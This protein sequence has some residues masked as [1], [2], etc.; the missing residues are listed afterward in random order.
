M[1]DIL[2]SK[3]KYYFILYI[4]FNPLNEHQRPKSAVVHR[5]VYFSASSCYQIRK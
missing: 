1:D 5:S 4:F 3:S 2:A